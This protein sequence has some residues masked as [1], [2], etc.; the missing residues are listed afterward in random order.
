[1]LRMGDFCKLSTNC[2]THKVL[3]LREPQYLSDRLLYRDEV[4]QRVSLER[5]QKG[6]KAFTHFFVSDSVWSMDF[7]IRFPIPTKKLPL[8]LLPYLDPSVTIVRYYCTEE[9]MSRSTKKR[10]GQPLR[11]SE[12][13][14]FQP[15]LFLPS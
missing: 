12:V 2:M 14:L 10:L 4:S 1:M 5:S 7:K 8:F 13:S 3:L 11:N 15:L 9:D 6:K